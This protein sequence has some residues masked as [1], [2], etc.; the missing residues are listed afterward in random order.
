MKS[1]LVTILIIAMLIGAGLYFSSRAV[2]TEAPIVTPDVA[3][4]SVTASTTKIHKA[5]TKNKFTADIE[6]PVI[7]GHPH[8][9]K[10]NKLIQVR[11]D[12]M[13]EAFSQTAVEA[14]L[15]MPDAFKN[16]KHG[17]IG[18]AQTTI[19]RDRYVSILFTSEYDIVSAAHP[20][21]SIESFVYDLDSLKEVLLEDIFENV[22]QAL[23]YISSEATVQVK[24]KLVEN[25]AEES[26]IKDGLKP[27]EANFRTFSISSSGIMFSFSE[28]QVAPYAAGAQSATLSW[29]TMRPLLTPQF[30]VLTN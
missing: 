8:A 27:V 26:F 1:F 23:A 2:P 15:G 5:D 7:S 11:V 4:G 20:Y 28:Y 19:V 9:E 24:A 10:L 13:L 14:N 25:Q 22:S 12:A 30:K 21:H 18:D 17:L 29:N 6:I 3:D 16:E